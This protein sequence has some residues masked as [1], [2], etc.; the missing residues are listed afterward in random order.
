MRTEQATAIRLQDYR[1]PDWLVDTV[2]LDFSLDPEATRVRTRLQLRP[3]PAAEAA[4]PVVLEGDGLELVGLA[5]DGQPV[6]AEL[7]S[8]HHANIARWRR[9]QSLRLTAARRPELLE[10]ARANGWLT[11]ADER[12][13]AALGAPADRN[14]KS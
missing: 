4:A 13:L 6:P 8:G 7:L 11:R 2:E 14:P 9:E 1:P 3:N 5:I 10:K 12:F